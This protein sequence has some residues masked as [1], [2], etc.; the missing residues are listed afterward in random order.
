VKFE[1]RIDILHTL[2]ELEQ[3]KILLTQLNESLTK[4]IDP[5]ILILESDRSHS[6]RENAQLRI[7]VSELRKELNAKR[8]E[9]IRL[10]EMLSHEFRTPLVPIKAY[11][12]M[13]LA[14]KFGELKKEQKERLYLV[15]SSVD[16]M[17]N[18][19]DD[20]ILTKQFELEPPKLN[21]EVVDVKRLVERAVSNLQEKAKRKGIN[22][23]YQIPQKL[24]CYCDN[25]RILFVLTRVIE[26]LIATISKP[27]SKITINEISDDRYANVAIRGNGIG[28][29]KQVFSLFTRFFP[30]IRSSTREKKGLGLSPFLYKQIIDLHGGKMEYKSISGEE[31]EIHIMIPKR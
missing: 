22:I 10:S 27:Q 28:T 2:R 7:L 30:A 17:Q 13:L 6:E 29:S 4:K 20:L 26:N 23:T 31:M 3:R 8:K 21:K 15:K 14:D 5:L 11:T 1:K 12:D 18:L 19:L 25:E 9:I 16:V 24:L